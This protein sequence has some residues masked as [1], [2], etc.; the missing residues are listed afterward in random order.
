MR[1]RQKGND[2]VART[3]CTTSPRE[4]ICLAG[5]ALENIRHNVSVRQHY[6]LGMTSRTRRIHKECQIFVRVHFDS[7]IA[8]CSSQIPDRG[9]MLKAHSLVSVMSY[10]DNAILR[11]TDLFGRLCCSRQQ[12]FLGRQRLGPSILQLE[13]KFIGS[14]A[15]IRWGDDTACPM[16]TPYYGW[17][18][19]AVCGEQS[20]HIPFSPFPNRSEAFAKVD[21]RG[22]DLG[23]GVGTLGLGVEVDDYGIAFL[24]AM[25]QSRRWL[26][27]FVIREGSIVA[28][29]RQSPEV[30]RRD[31]NGWVGGFCRHLGRL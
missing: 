14:V 7:P 1:E 3:V 11:N 23:I 4:V 27:T 31:V 20:K 28:L 30:G 6:A 5:F 12:S 17:R 8:V 9:E 18:V 25:E 15:G 13:S 10:E 24:R 29:E 22:F 26:H 21:G 2:S 16:A 19:D